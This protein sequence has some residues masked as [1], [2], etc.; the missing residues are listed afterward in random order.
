LRLRLVDLRAR[1]APVVAELIGGIGIAGTGGVAVGRL[2]A[3][4][5]IAKGDSR[6]LVE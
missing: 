3:I 6:D 2:A 1:G 5:I 4:G